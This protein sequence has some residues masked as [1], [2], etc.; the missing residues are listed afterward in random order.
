MRKNIRPI[1]LMR[2][3]DF[4]SYLMLI[5]KQNVK[6]LP[7]FWKTCAGTE[8]PA[9]VPELRS[10]TWHL[11]VSKCNCISA[12]LQ[13]LYCILLSTCTLGATT[14]T[15]ITN[16]ILIITHNTPWYSYS[17]H[18]H[19]MNHTC[20]TYIH[21]HSVVLYIHGLHTLKY[22]DVVCQAGEHYKSNKSVWTQKYNNK[23]ILFTSV[24]AHYELDDHCINIYYR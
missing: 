7:R 2:D 1:T 22:Q 24:C 8:I 12:V 13:V 11:A 10:L 20:T 16:I 21:I 9:T 6:K 18:V 17:A 15:T 14:T 4:D 23:S 5:W 19:H 3:R